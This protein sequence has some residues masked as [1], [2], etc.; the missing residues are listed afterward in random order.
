[1]LDEPQQH[2]LDTK[3]NLGEALANQTEGIVAY[4]QTSHSSNETP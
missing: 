3:K 4:E 2:S 1:M